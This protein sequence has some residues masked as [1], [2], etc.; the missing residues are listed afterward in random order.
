[1]HTGRMP[2]TMSSLC[3]TLAEGSFYTE[4]FDKLKLAS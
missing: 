3:S 1:M 4:G 2:V